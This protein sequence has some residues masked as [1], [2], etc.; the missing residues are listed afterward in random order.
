[1][2]RIIYYNIISFI[3]IIL[4]FEIILTF[5]PVNQSFQF[6]EVNKNSFIF[7]AKENRSIT[8]SKYWNF[9]NPQIIKINNLDF[10]MIMIMMLKNKI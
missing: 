10:E 6:Y 5:L 3:I 7:R 4:F 8:Q 1:M 9:Y 2:L